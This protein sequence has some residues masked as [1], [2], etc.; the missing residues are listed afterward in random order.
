MTDARSQQTQTVVSPAVD[1]AVRDLPGRGDARDLR[2]QWDRGDARDP[3]D[4]KDLEVFLVRRVFQDRPE[5]WDR[6]VM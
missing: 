2:G 3:K 5:Q 6:R 4:L 1:A